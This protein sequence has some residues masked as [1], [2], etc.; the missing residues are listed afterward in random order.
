MVKYLQLVYS[1][2]DF[3]V[4]QNQAKWKIKGL[5]THDAM[6]TAATAANFIIVINYA[7]RPNT[8]IGCDDLFDEHFMWNDNISIIPDILFDI[9]C[10]AQYEAHYNY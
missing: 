1:I 6:V 10:R 4:E 5:V 7:S 9:K 2:C 3:I 8:I